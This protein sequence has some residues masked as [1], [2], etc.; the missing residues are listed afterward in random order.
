M[1]AYSD[2]IGY[3]LEYHHSS[4][5]LPVLVMM[6]GCMGSGEAFRPIAE[7]LLSHCNPL[8]IDLA[9]HGRTQT[10][11]DPALFSTDRQVNQ[12]QS[13]LKRLSLSPMIGY[14][15]S[16]GGRLLLQLAV[17]H[18]E[19]FDGLFIESSHCGLQSEQ[20]KSIRIKEDE[21]RARRIET[22]FNSFIDDWLR[23][24]L[25]SGTSDKQ[26][27]KYRKLMLSQDPKLL[28]C[29][30]RGFGAGS[31]PSVCDRL[32]HLPMPLYLIAGGQDERYVNRMSEMSKKCNDCTFQIV[33]GAGHRVHADRPQEIAEMIKHTLET[34]YHVRV[35]NR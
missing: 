32:Q 34:R 20:E 10:P 26:T 3:Y 31:M 21:Q 18:P 12:L 8:L 11:A 23:L 35:E 16:M 22:E 27:A 24:P 33:E 29:S 19:L 6:H 14:G 25:F 28:A 7:N 30:L 4:R 9:G 13:V 15:Y 5:N 17:K 2:G 1:I